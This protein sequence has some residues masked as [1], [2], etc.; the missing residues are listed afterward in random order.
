MFTIEIKKELQR[1]RQDFEEQASQYHDLTLSIHFLIRGQPQEEVLFKHHNHTIALWQYMGNVTPQTDMKE[2]LNFQPTDFGLTQAEVTAYGVVEG[3]KTDLFRRMAYRVGSLIPD[4][5]SNSLSTKVM[6]NFADPE[7]LGKAVF[8][9]NSNPLAIW[10]TFTLICVATFQPRRFRTQTLAVDPFTASLSVFDYFLDNIDNRSVKTQ[11]MNPSPL[12]KKQFKVALSFP[13]EKRD[14]VSQV[15]AGL[16]ER[17][18]DIFYDEYFEAELAQPDLD[19]ILQTI[20][21]KNSD[22]VVVLICKEYD[23]K[24]WCGLEWR[25]IRDLLKQRKGSTIMPMRFDDV[26]IPGLFS[27]DGYINLQGRAPEQAVD[28]ICRRIESQEETNSR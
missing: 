19:I 2:F 28:I 20:Y 22:L 24:E 1:L 26:E 16:Q 12:L 25:A 9:P 3:N 15:A 5:V 21:H 23:K 10:L 17:I 6:N 11:N 14:F 27:I 4:S 13:G 18:S 8:V 7:R